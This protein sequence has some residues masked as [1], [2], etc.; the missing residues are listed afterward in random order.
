[1]ARKTDW[2]ENTSARVLV[3]ASASINRDDIDDVIRLL[4]G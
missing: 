2:S 4:G 3:V 1:M